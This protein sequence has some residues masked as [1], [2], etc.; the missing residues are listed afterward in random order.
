[1]HEIDEEVGMI[2]DVSYMDN[3]IETIR[4]YTPGFIEEAF[5]SILLQ[6]LKELGLEG[7]SEVEKKDVFAALEDQQMIVSPLMIPNKLIPRIDEKTGEE[8][9][10]YFTADTIKKIAYKFMSEKLLDR[11][12]LEHDTEMPVQGASIVESWIVEDP[13]TDKGRIYGFAVP[14]GAWIA[15]IKVKNRKFWMEKVKTGLT[16]GLSVEG[17]FSDMVM[18]YSQESFVDPRAGESEEEF[19]GRCI[20]NNKREGYPDDQAAAMCYSKWDNR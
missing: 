12:N 7:L 9:Y 3:H 16:K 15:M 14:P 18:S 17:Y 5:A 6:D 2:H 4:S 8:Y 11:F 13:L 10:V 19:I 1:M 20:A